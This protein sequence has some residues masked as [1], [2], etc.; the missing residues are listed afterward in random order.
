VG[1]ALVPWLGLRW[2]RNKS[3]PLLPGFVVLGISAMKSEACG[4][5]CQQ[6]GS[7]AGAPVID[8]LCSSG[9]EEQRG[10]RRP[11]RGQDVTMC[12]R[13]GRWS[14]R[15]RIEELLV[16]SAALCCTEGSNDMV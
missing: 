4:K 9:L 11:G 16:S 10:T 13:Y 8:S 6:K 2:G 15:K 5:V 3:S 7:I 1:T 12:G 14:R